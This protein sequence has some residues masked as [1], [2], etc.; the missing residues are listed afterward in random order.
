MVHS[1]SLLQT[2]L[3]LVF[4][5]LSI[6]A[7]AWLL[8]RWQRPGGGALSSMHVKGQL[9]VGPRE[10]VVLIEVGDQ[11]IVAGVASGSVQPL[12]VLPRQETATVEDTGAP[13][14]VPDFAALLERLGRKPR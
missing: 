3:A 1:A 13:A 14:A 8:R 12:A 11:W 4:V 2:A 6:V 7:V 5:L 9:M 10:R